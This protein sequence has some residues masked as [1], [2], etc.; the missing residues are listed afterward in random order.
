MY[1]TVSPA[2]AVDETQALLW[3][4]LIPTYNYSDHIILQTDL[5]SLNIFPQGKCVNM[6]V[7]QSVSHLHNREEFFVLA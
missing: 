2:A 7:Y 5:A 6:S 3:T 1:V 4:L